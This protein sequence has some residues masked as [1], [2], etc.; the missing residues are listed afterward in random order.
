ML[1]CFFFNRSIKF[2]DSKARKAS[3]SMRACSPSTKAFYPPTIRHSRSQKLMADSLRCRSPS[4]IAINP[5][6]LPAK[7][8]SGHFLHFYFF[9]KHQNPPYA[10]LPYRFPLAPDSFPDA[11]VTLQATPNHRRMVLPVRKMCRAAADLSNADAVKY[12]RRLPG[13]D[14]LIRHRAGSFGKG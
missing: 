14:R 5:F 3:I 10:L 11:P 12:K 8:Y 1:F 7:I 4:F 9:F 13:G 2:Q 6:S